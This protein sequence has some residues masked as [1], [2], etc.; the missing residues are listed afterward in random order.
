LENVVQVEL[1]D[2]KAC[3][4]QKD[5]RFSY[6][7]SSKANIMISEKKY[8]GSLGRSDCT[9]IHN[10]NF[11]TKLGKL[12]TIGN[13]QPQVN[14]N[15]PFQLAEK[16]LEAVIVPIKEDSTL[17]V[18]I[19]TLNTELR[20]ITTERSTQRKTIL[21][22]KQEIQSLHETIEL[23]TI[24]I[25]KV[26]KIFTNKTK[27]NAK[28]K[29]E[30]EEQIHAVNTQIDNHTKTIAKSK[31]TLLSKKNENTTKE[32]AIKT[33]HQEIEEQKKQIQLNDTD[34]AT[35]KKT[36]ISNQTKIENLKIEKKNQM[37]ENETLIQTNEKEI[38]ILDNE[39]NK[40]NKKIGKQN[41]LIS[42]AITKLDQLQEQKNIKKQKILDQKFEA[43]NQ[44]LK[45]FK[46][47]NDKLEVEID[48]L[49]SV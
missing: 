40:Q 27:E 7:D 30:I 2:D 34:I 13:P 29:S 3:F 28:N 38:I 37:K 42:E 20:T 44:N 26:K 19:E 21:D 18:K 47:L 35:L 24:Q 36:K 49:K 48:Q 10:S 39:I 1:D 12:W 9:D 22:L 33:L 16:V 32:N 15:R 17:S 41:P 6:W 45:E 43:I 4:L 11:Y 14:T 23:D 8:D 31:E 25:E 5:G 46:S